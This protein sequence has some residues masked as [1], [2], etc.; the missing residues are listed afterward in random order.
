MQHSTSGLEEL[1]AAL[2]DLNNHLLP[3]DHRR[4][5]ERALLAWRQQDAAWAI[6]VQLLGSSASPDLVLF[7]AQTLRYKINEQAS[8]MEQ[9]QLQQLRDLLLQHLSKPAAHAAP[10]VLRQTCL[11]LADLAALLPG[12]EDV[13]GTAHARLPQLHCVEL[14]HSIA[15]EG[16]SDWRHVHM[17]GAMQQYSSTA[18]LVPTLRL[19]TKYSCPTTLYS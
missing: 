18:M 3:P 11:A 14:L 2:K 4:A 17:P 5:T 8:S 16:S 12:W 6:A 19:L 1:E 13:I 15:D 9:A 7:A 10:A